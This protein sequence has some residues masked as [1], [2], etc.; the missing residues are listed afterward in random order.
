MPRKRWLALGVDL[1]ATIGFP[2]EYNYL[3][4]ALE[5]YLIGELNP[6]EN[7]AKRKPAP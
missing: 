4:L 7:S 1:L 5:D 3:A 2:P 6:S